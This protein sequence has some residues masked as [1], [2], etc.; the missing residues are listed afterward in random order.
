MVQIRTVHLIPEIVMRIAAPGREHVNFA[1]RSEAELIHTE[2]RQH[3]LHVHHSLFS[4]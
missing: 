4:E 1:E 2:L 3:I